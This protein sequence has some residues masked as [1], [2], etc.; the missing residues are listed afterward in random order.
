MTTKALNSLRIR[1]VLSCPVGASAHSDQDIYCLHA[2][3]RIFR[4]LSRV[5]RLQWLSQMRVRLVIRKSR[6][7]SPPTPA[8]FF[9]EIDH[10][11]FS[12]AISSP[13]PRPSPPPPHT[14]T[15][16][17][18][19]STT[20]RTTVVSFKQFLQEEIEKVQNECAQVMVN[21]LED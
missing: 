11:I 14:H 16:T 17:H 6:V 4:Y 5:D 9:L 18:P 2:T 1:E 8:K 10:E 13:H 12:T 3:N 21:H 19:P 15:H 7:R 20:S